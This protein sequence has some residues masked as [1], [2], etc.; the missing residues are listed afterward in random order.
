[1]PST[2]I[3]SNRRKNK[4]KI[5]SIC[6]QKGGVGKTTTTMNL[7]AALVQNGLKVLCIDLDSQG[8]LSGYLGYE[9][10]VKQTITDLLQAAANGKPFDPVPAIRKNDEGIY[11][12]PSDIRLSSMEIR[13]SQIMF[14]EQILSRVLAAPALQQFDYILIDCLPSLGILL[15]N[16][17][18]ASNGIIIPVQAQQFALEGLDDLLNVY[19]MVKQQGNPSLKIEGVLLTM[20]DNT[21]ASRLIETELRKRFGELVF[22]VSISRLVEAVESTIERR[23]LVSDITSRLGGQYADVAEELIERMG[24]KHGKES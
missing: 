11:Y 13:L 14:R 12:I 16:A 19:G 17:L 22:E 18:I 6:N 10:G 7:A 20:T 9:T 15:T 8:N 24:E 5:I 3:Y 4:M 2:N 23:S 21:V 1:M